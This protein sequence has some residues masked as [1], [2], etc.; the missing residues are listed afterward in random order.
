MEAIDSEIDSLQAEMSRNSPPIIFSKDQI[1]CELFLF[2]SYV[3]GWGLGQVKG[4]SD[5]RFYGHLALLDEELLI[6][7]FAHVELNPQ[8]LVG[9]ED[10]AVMSEHMLYMINKTKMYA[11]CE[12]EYRQ[13]RIPKGAF[14]HLLG[15][16]FLVPMSWI[17]STSHSPLP[18]SNYIKVV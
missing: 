17:R 15:G 9:R 2:F 6:N 4:F 7:N 5:E 18:Y 1:K 10:R 8:F 3:G 13:D 14:A 16:I 11:E 12:K